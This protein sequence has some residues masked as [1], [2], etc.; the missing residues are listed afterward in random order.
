MVVVQ[1]LLGA[2]FRIRRFLST[3]RFVRAKHLSPKPKTL[4]ADGPRCGGPWARSPTTGRAGPRSTSRRSLEENKLRRVSSL[5]FRHSGVSG[6]NK[7]DLQGVGWHAFGESTETHVSPASR[8]EG[9][10][11]SLFQ[12]WVLT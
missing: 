11:L 3:P 2:C 12:G 5:G 4:T 8:H 7:E 10:V 6:R 9:K 1:Q